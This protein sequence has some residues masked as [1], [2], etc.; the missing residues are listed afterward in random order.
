MASTFCPKCLLKAG[1]GTQFDIEPE[2]STVA[3]RSSKSSKGLPQPGEL[4][5]HY[6]MI[7]LLGQGGMGVVYEAEDLESG[8]RIALK[9]L[10]QALDS[11]DARKRFLREGQLAASINHPNSVYVFGTEEIGGTPVIAMELMVGGTLQDR[12]IKDG[13]LSVAQ[14]VDS[15]LQI[16]AGLEA[17]RKVGI[18]HRD[19]KPSNCFIDSDGT[20]KIGD[21][22]LSISTVVRTE[23]NVTEAAALFGTPAYSSPEQLRGDELSVRSDIYSVGV[24][25]YQLL[26]GRMPFEAANVVQLLATVLERR[27]ESPAKWRPEIPKGLGRVVLRCLEKDAGDRFASYDK[28][29]E[30]LLPYGSSAP[31]LATP[32]VRFLAGCIDV[33]LP[34]PFCS[35]GAQFFESRS[36]LLVSTLTF[37][38]IILSYYC[39]FE[40]IL[41][42]GAGKALFGLR[43]VNRVGNPP[44]LMRAFLRA[45]IFVGVSMVGI[46]VVGVLV[47]DHIGNKVIEGLIAI[48]V[49]FVLLAL[50]FVPA[51]KSNGFLGLHDFGSRTRVMLKSSMVTR[52]G[53]PSKDEQTP[54][55]ETSVRIG[56]YHVLGKVGE[57]DGGE[58]LLGYDAR[59]LRKVWIRK[60]PLGTPSLGGEVRNRARAGRLRWLNDKRTEVEA[61]DAY[62]ALSGRPLSN[63]LSEQQSWERVRFWLLDLAEELHAAQK[64]DSIPVMK[65]DHL[66]ITDDGHA[67]LLDFPAPGAVLAISASEENPPVS[68]P[69]SHEFL[70]VV[71]ASA[72]CGPALGM[73]EA[74]RM[75]VALPIAL[76]ARNLLEKIRREISPQEVANQ[77]RP[78][79]GKI[80]TISR[81][82]RLALIMGGL[83]FPIFL[84]LSLVFMKDEDG[85]S[86]A[87]ME[88]LWFVRL[89]WKYAISVVVVPCLISALLFRG[90]A[91]MHGLGI[92]LVTKDG[93]LAS[94]GRVLWRNLLAW[95][96]L[97]L[98]PRLA[99]LLGLL[100]GLEQATSVLLPLLAILTIVSSILPGRSLQDRLAGTFPVPR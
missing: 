53:L 61:W 8:R 37:W 77:L 18:L 52:P 69:A 23:S 21:F 26:T 80:A 43:T 48:C 4:F 85:S 5:G 39:L 42:A 83:W 3:P 100:I 55:T 27:A 65:L 86:L 20:V 44:G 45:V 40:G 87:H 6:Q 34:I 54:N 93:K 9:I 79:L 24:M 31:G 35:F 91:L 13:P 41:G 33:S 14:A 72:L 75:S 56:P 88:M 76:H 16:I 2:E 60:L 12:L 46:D 84:P 64:S 70:Y 58:I 32:G 73:R 96:P 94:R 57:T 68:P 99:V 11:P 49:Y 63:L 66:W 50:T 36:W 95:L 92:V 17:A 15:V 81:A 82:R 78:L 1:L 25:L 47:S 90:G 74:K 19:I 7:R 59:L 71:A 97:M 30:A 22:G 38:T 28:L 62:E 98:L 67:K 89:F 51:R 10:G 29:R